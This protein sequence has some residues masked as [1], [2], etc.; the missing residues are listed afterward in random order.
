MKVDL[1]K[2]LVDVDGNPAKDENGNQLTLYRV[3]SISLFSGIKD[4]Q[5]TDLGKLDKCWE[6][7]SKIKIDEPVELK[8]DDLTFIK[9]RIGKLYGSIP[10]ISGQARYLLDQEFKSKEDTKS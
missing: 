4:Q 5:E 2:V 1:S 10:G 7:K 3:C 6:L 8:S 9:E